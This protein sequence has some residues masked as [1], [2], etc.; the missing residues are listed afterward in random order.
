[1]KQIRRIVLFSCMFLLAGSLDGLSRNPAA[2]EQ[3]IVF[4]AVPKKHVFKQ[5]EDIVLFFSIQNNSADD[6]FV[7]RLAGDEFVDIKLR[8]PDGKEVSWQ[9]TGKIDS[10]NYSASEFAVLKKNE[11]IRAFRIISVKD[12][13]GFL[14]QENGQYS[15]VAE[16]LLAP[17]DY[18]APLAGNAKIPPESLKS[19]PATFCIETCNVSPPK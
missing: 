5:K 13:R 11:S 12:G 3:A 4:R 10:R 15:L 14:F 17:S 18:F 9:G 16:Y 1:M 7:S 8:G 19:S 6:V 2:T